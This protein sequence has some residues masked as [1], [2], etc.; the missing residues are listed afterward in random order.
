VRGV[1]SLP[2]FTHTGVPSFMPHPLKDITVAAKGWVAAQFNQVL[3]WGFDFFPSTTAA[4]K[5]SFGFSMSMSFSNMLGISLSTSG[6]T[7]C[8]A[9]KMIVELFHSHTLV[10]RITALLLVKRW[11][12]WRFKNVLDCW[13]V[14]IIV[15][16]VRTNAVSLWYLSC[17]Y[18]ARQSTRLRRS[19]C[20]A[21]CK[22]YK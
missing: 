14:I 17:Q 7:T 8:H 21:T 9:E 19:K 2:K 1:A 5:D 4:K 22:I 15:G 18:H 3:Y 16:S 20:K 6:F 12:L 13:Y 11:I 10:L